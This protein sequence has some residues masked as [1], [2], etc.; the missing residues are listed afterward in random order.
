M[1]PILI[2]GSLMAV[3]LVTRSGN[4][5]PVNICLVTFLLGLI[6]AK[7][8]HRRGYRRHSSG[9]ITHVPQAPNRHSGAA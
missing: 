5:T 1:H 9:P 8:H 3:F 2:L 7:V 6:F 4:P